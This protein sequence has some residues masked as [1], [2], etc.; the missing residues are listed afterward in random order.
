MLCNTMWLQQQGSSR[1]DEANYA[2]P[3]YNRD[4]TQDRYHVGKEL[5]GKK[6]GLISLR[7]TSGVLT[8]ASAGKVP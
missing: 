5:A 8:L 6:T 3:P 7:L 2:K 4:F 1:R